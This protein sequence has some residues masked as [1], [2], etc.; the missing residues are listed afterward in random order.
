MSL[1]NQGMN[2]ISD[3]SRDFLLP[4]C[5]QAGSAAH[6]ASHLI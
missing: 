6:T 1:N 3:N 4:Q 2:D 5:V